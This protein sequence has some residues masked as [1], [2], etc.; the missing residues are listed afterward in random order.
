MEERGEEM[1]FG[2]WEIEG[3]VLVYA[4]LYILFCVSTYQK[5]FSGLTIHDLGRYVFVD[6]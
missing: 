3:G 1:M 6:F 5:K 2:Q 4:R